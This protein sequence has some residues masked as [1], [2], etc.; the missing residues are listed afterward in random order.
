[1]ADQAVSASVCSFP[2]AG[3]DHSAGQPS[4]GAADGGGILGGPASPVSSSPSGS[5]GL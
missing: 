5:P 4:H 2:Q 3:V 1:M